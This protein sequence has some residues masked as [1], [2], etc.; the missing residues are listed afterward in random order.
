MAL[1]TVEALQAEGRI[2]V[3][4]YG[5]DDT[6]DANAAG[7]SRHNDRKHDLFKRYLHKNQALLM[8]MGNCSWGGSYEEPCIYH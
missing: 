1:A 3:M 7:K 6:D 5:V 4:V 2:D 8:G